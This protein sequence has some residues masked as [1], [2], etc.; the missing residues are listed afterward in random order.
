MVN[1]GNQILV[2]NVLILFDVTEKKARISLV[3]D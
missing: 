3:N 1:L 2:V